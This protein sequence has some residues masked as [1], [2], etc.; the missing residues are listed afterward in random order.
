LGLECCLLRVL[1]D[2]HEVHDRFGFLD[3]I[4]EA[5]PPSSSF[6]VRRLVEPLEEPEEP[7]GWVPALRSGVLGDD[8]MM[9]TAGVMMLSV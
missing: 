6:G 1:A 7:E 8:E 9:G 5:R 2:N 4:A 3:C